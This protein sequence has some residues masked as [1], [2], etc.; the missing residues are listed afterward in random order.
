L[1]IDPL[2]KSPLGDTG[3]SV[4]PICLG[5]SMRHRDRDLA[6]GTIRAVFDSPI[7][8]LDT[9]RSYNRGLN[10]ELIGRVIR[11]RGGLPDGFVLA[12]KAD[13]DFDTQE[14]DGA[15]ARQSVEQSLETLGLDH[16]QLVHLHDPEYCDM[17]EI[18]A[19]GGPI[20][21]LI[22]LRDEGLIGSVGLAAGRVDIMMQCL[23][24]APFDVLLIHNRHTLLND[25][26]APLIDLAVSRGIPFINA[27]PYGSGVLAK[28]SADNPRYAYQ[29][30]FA[31]LVESTRRL[32]AICA[33]HGVSLAAAALQYSMRD[34]R[35]AV[36]LIGAGDPSR[37]QQN[38]DLARV[39]IPDAIWPELRA[40][41]DWH[42]DPEAARGL[43]AL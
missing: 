30:A 43:P 28:G 19:A 9:A 38:I 6:L 22:E 11:E 23:E 7:N 40:V 16:L 29:P 10:E 8:F 12:T 2:Q 5:L 32:E 36:S 17:D 34:P 15:R 27:A 21:T 18:L 20:D 37:I 25:N 39:A 1:P 42:D 41:L 13:R 35:V 26:A 14:F 4:T 31:A 24:R 33:A 3:L